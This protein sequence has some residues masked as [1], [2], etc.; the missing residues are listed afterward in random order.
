MPKAALPIVPLRDLIVFPKQ[1][2]SL[3]VGRESSL[4]A[5]EASTTSHDHR[6][7]VVAQ[8]DNQVDD[9]DIDDIQSVGCLV[10]I[11]QV[12]KSE[13][14]AACLVEIEGVERTKINFLQG[15]QDGYLSAGYTCLRSKS[16]NKVES[17]VYTV[18]KLLYL[19]KKLA[20]VESDESREKY[21]KLLNSLRKESDLERF[22]DYL[23]VTLTFN[24]GIQM[25]ILESREI[26]LRY[27]KLVELLKSRYDEIE[28]ER[29]LR[30]RVKKQIETNQ[31]EY[32]LSEQAKAIQKELN[33]DSAGDDLQ[34]YKNKIKQADMSAEAKDKCLRELTK[35][36]NMPHISAETTVVRSYLDWMLKLPWG[37]RSYSSINLKHCQRI[38]NR[39][40]YGLEDVKERILE[41]LAVSKKVNSS[42]K[43]PVICLVGPPGVGKTSLARSIAES[44][45][46][47]YVRFSLG[48]LRDEAEIRGHRRTY[49]GSMP[50]KIIQNICTAGTMNPV[51][52][53]DEIDKMSH[54]FRGDPGSALLEVLDP[55]QNSKFNDLYLEI[56]YDLS[57]VMF[58]CTANSLNIAQPLMDRMEIIQLS[59]YTEDEKY[60]IAR[61][62]LLPKQIQLHGF[63]KGQVGISEA[64]YKSIIRKYTREAGVRNLEKSVA[65]ILRK[66]A[67]LEATEDKDY[68][69]QLRGNKITINLDQLENYLG[70]PRYRKSQEK[71]DNGV[72]VVTG[73]AWTSVGGETLTIEALLLGGRGDIVL[74]GSLGDVM[75]ESM[76]TALSIVRSRAYIFNIDADFAKKYDFH[77]HIP[78]GATP[79]DG[80]SAGIGICIALLSSLA[81]IPV[82][83]NVAMTG[84]VNLRG[85]VMPVGGIKE[86]LLAAHREGVKTVLIPNDNISDLAKVP[87]KVKESLSII[88][89][90]RIEEVI[91]LALAEVPDS[92]NLKDFTGLQHS[93]VNLSSNISPSSPDISAAN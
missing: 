23:A 5:L 32:F 64:A 9:P 70:A 35:L 80:P 68:L 44:V 59:E 18:D 10:N 34:D 36:Q 19:L 21:A 91:R 81:S 11:L 83:A 50:G 37:K 60:N 62:H 25:E 8:K 74:T 71:S 86:K 84:E 58:I 77:I 29:N 16:L 75:K 48:G 17:K 38:L 92:V 61:S 24:P 66:I 89:V 63:K 73:L 33:K 3:Y 22:I 65:K 54:D 85:L 7:L 42:N 39:D 79:K 2:V 43:A 1:V 53:L 87:T 88:P 15:D 78:E 51:I 82:R 55:E 67:F 76:R 14:E 72:G 6:M 27:E 40:H 93:I 26:S 90:S 41:H 4:K 28:L 45:G 12:S 49:I 31:R 46:R 56:D 13:R 57:E 20:G 52:L 30:E 69:S 47:E